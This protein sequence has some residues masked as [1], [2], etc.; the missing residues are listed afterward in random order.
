MLQDII[1]SSHFK[2]LYIAGTV[3]ICVSF[4]DTKAHLDLTPRS[5]KKR[6]VEVED[7]EEH[8]HTVQ[9]KM[10]LNCILFY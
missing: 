3:G 7:L 10:C 4:S 8:M 5:L 2:L 1:F 6:V 9:F